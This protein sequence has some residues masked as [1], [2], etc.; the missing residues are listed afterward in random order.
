MINQDARIKIEKI[1]MQ[2]NSIQERKFLDQMVDLLDHLLEDNQKLRDR[3]TE[4]S[5]A[6]Y[7]DKSGGQFT[8]EEID[9]AGRGG[10]GW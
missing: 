3:N 9:R 6:L 8:Q 4:M 7:P 2:L 1:K 5:W 10:E